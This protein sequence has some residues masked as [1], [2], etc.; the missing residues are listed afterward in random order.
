[1]NRVQIGEIGNYY[2]DLSIKKEGVK[3][4]WG[5]EDYDGTDWEEIPGYLYDA[6]M[7]FQYTIPTWL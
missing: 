1:M 2:G 3:F 5:I 7:K 6:L 4:Y